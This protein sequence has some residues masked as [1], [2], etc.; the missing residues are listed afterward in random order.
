MLQ[1][2]I[3]THT[4]RCTACAVGVGNGSRPQQH[5]LHCLGSRDIRFGRTL[6]YGHCDRN[7]GER[8]FAG[9]YNIAGGCDFIQR[10]LHD[11]HIEQFALHHLLLGAV[12][13]AE[14]GIDLMPGLALEIGN[15][16]LDRRADA[17]GRDQRHFISHGAATVEGDQCNDHE[18]HQV[19]HGCSS[20]LCFL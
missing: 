18:R 19:F 16:F 10:R 17:A 2:R 11:R 12:A 1:R 13:R 14:G 4:R 9:I 15:H 6:A 20:V 3:E 7:G 5:F 8:R